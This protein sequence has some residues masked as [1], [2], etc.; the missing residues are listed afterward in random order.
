MQKLKTTTK[1]VTTK[2][3]QDETRLLLAL[4][5]L[6]GTKTEVKTTE[7]TGSVQRKN[8]KAGDYTS[9][10]RKLEKAGAINSKRKSKVETVQLTD[11]GLQMLDEQLKTLDFQFYGKQVGSKVASK[12]VGGLLKWIREINGAAFVSTVEQSEIAA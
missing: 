12:F 9:V 5:D 4:W 10:L 2:R 7:V 1:K 3:N 6:G 8:E 11:K